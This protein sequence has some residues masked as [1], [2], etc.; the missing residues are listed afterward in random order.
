MYGEMDFK[1]IQSQ[2]LGR[3]DVVLQSLLISGSFADIYLATLRTTN[4]TVVA[5][6]LKSKSSFQSTQNNNG[7]VLIIN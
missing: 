7:S 3:D 6:V 4:E 2:H 1:D 5:K